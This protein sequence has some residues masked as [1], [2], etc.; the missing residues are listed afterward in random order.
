[1]ITPTFPS[2][3]SSHRRA[4][5]ITHVVGLILIVVAGGLLI[6]KSAQL[7]DFR[8]VIAVSVYV[9]C[10]MASNLA[11]YTYHFAP[12][13]DHRILL[14]RI[15]HAAIYPSITGTFTPFFVLASTPW[16]IAL[17]WVSWAL[18]VLAIWKKI[19]GNV[20]QGRWSTAS[21]LALGAIG[22]SAL[23]D[24]RDVPAGSLWL[25]V[26]GAASFVIGTVFYTRRSMRF[27]YAVWH[28]WVNI[29][30][31]LMFASIWIALFPPVR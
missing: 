15:D 9:A 2:I 29:G 26:A 1:M 6:T 8:L 18:A 21:Y 19:S 13:H 11:S 16:T 24:L 27:R 22:L 5:L 12:W 10:A 7:L 30:G 31:I 17:L 23:P 25:I 3:A 14:R 28:V 20:V 4:D